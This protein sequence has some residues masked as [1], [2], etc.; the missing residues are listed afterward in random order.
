MRFQF[1]EFA[2]EEFDKAIEF[3]ESCSQGLGVDFSKEIY[4]AIERIVRHPD[5]WTPISKNTRRCL[6]NRFPFGVIYKILNDCIYIIAV[7]DL[8]RRPNYW[9]DRRINA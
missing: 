5:A 8:R 1:H 3:Y 7:A 9:R 2:E 4:A 6:A